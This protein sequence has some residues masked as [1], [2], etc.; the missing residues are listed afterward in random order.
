MQS[1]N[2]CYSAAHDP[3]ERAVYSHEA[4]FEA[5]QGHADGGIFKGAAEAFFAFP[6]LRLGFFEVMNVRA[7]AEPRDSA[8][9]VSP[10]VRRGSTTGGKPRP[11]DV[12]TRRV[13]V[14]FRRRVLPGVPSTLLVIRMKRFCSNLGQGF[15]R[16]SVRCNPSSAD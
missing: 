15:P 4:A 14:E 11:R 13:G 9:G 1:S 2:S 6:Q 16:G 8:I 12:G 10:A 7:G 5:E 3:A